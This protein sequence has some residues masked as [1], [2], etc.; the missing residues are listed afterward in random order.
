MSVQDLSVGHHGTASC[1]Y[2]VRLVWK[3][4]QRTAHC[5]DHGK[6]GVET[7]YHMPIATYSIAEL[8]A[9]HKRRRGAM[10]I[11]AHSLSHLHLLKQNAAKPNN[12]AVELPT[13]QQKQNVVPKRKARSTVPRRHNALHIVKTYWI[14]HSFAYT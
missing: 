4:P 11:E 14:R 5:N 13:K 1:R 7:W 3:A 9:G 2:T 8:V 6:C 10:H 12:T